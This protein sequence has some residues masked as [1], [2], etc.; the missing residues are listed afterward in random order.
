MNLDQ[1][2]R[3]R[4]SDAGAGGN[5]S[6]RKNILLAHGGGGQLTDELLQGLV[7]PRLGN[8]VLSRMLDSATLDALGEERPALT[9]DSYVVQP[10]RFPGGD[11]GRLA[12]SGTVNDLAVS[13]ARPLGIALS[14]ILTEGLPTSV[15]ETV[16]DSVA[17]TAAE[18]NVRIVT[19]D[20]KVVGR[21]QADGVFITTAGLGAVPAGRCLAPELAR[22]GDVLLINGPIADHGL[23]VMLAREMPEMESVVASDAAPLNGLLL[24]LMEELGDDVAFARDATRGGLAGVAADLAR[25]CDLG[26]ALE[27][28]TVPVRPATRHAAEMLGLDPLDVANEGKAVVVVRPDVADWALEIMRRHPHGTDAA[29]IGRIAEE[30]AGRCILHTSLGGRRIVQKPYGEQLPRIC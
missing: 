27:E 18:A 5:E 29:V 7:L 1:V 10:W 22:P 16:L 19:G 13:G 11:V 3:P 6:A 14:L 2:S 9:I 20:T 15:V 21:G 8:S 24:S 17:A 26:V 4:A 12:V 30:P 25:D 23:A 28:E